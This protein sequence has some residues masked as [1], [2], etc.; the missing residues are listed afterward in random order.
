MQRRILSLALMT[1]ILSSTS[2]F[3]QMALPR[4]SPKASV[5]QTI[6]T[7]DVTIVYSRPGVKG[8]QIWGALVPFDKVWRTGANEAT[9]ITFSDDVKIN[10]SKLAKGAY[11]LHTIPSQ[12]EWTL[13]F[14][15]LIPAGYSHDESKDVLRV[16]VKPEAAPHQEWMLFTI[17]NPSMTS[18]QVE[19]RW[20]KIMVPFTIETDSMNKAIESARSTVD[21]W[22]APYQAAN[23]AFTN[24]MAGDDAMRWIDRSIAVKPGYTNLQLKAKMLAKRGDKKQAIA[25]MEKAIATGKA[26]KEP[27]D[28]TEGE[29]LLAEWKGK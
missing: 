6:G 16:K 7:T 23:F 24:D 10:G 4:P 17:P 19:L 9:T 1:L 2:V 8:R 28:M 12:N 22:R 20:D 11:S 27:P 5:M 14:N 29:K 13:I 26:A 25:M 21:D 18:A 3:A 15:S